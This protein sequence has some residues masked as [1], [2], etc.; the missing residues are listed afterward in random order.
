MGQNWVPQLIGSVNWMVTRHHLENHPIVIN[1]LRNY[2]TGDA[3]GYQ[4]HAARH[5]GAKDFVLSLHWRGFG[6]EIAQSED[7]NIQ[8]YPELSH[9]VFLELLY[10][11]MIIYRFIE[12]IDHKFDIEY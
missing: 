3:A 12:F 8:T 4:L 10:T 2:P 7:P 5:P 9:D 6:P 11:F 1:S